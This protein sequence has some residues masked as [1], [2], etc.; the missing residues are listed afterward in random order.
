[1]CC[2]DRLSARFLAPLVKNSWAG[3]IGEICERDGAWG[4]N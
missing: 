4:L 2:T 1:M 3:V